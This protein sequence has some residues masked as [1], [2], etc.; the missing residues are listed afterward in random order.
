MLSY[1][2]ILA[3][4]A[5]GYNDSLSYTATQDSFHTNKGM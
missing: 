5:I 3:G 1:K 4:R 2:T